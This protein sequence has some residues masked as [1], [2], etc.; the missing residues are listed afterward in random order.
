[1]TVAVRCEGKGKV[2]VK[3]KPAG[4]EFSLECLLGEVTTTYH[5]FAVQ[6]AEGK[7]V[8]SVQAPSSVR[9]SMTI[10]RGEAAGT[11]AE[12]ADPLA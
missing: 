9:W 6:S 10:G 2:L 3:V 11:E 1:M 7:G 12:D 5:Q 8:A 4:V